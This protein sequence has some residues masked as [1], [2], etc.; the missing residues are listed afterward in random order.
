[1]VPREPMG[2]PLAF[3]IGGVLWLIL[4]YLIVVPLL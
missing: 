3:W 2:L 1:M 4:F